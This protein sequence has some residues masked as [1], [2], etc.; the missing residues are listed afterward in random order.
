LVKFI[1]KKEKKTKIVLES[2]KYATKARKNIYAV[3]KTNE[4]ENTEQ[5]NAFRMLL[6]HMYLL[7]F[8]D[9]SKEFGKEIKEFVQCAKDFFEN[10]ETMKKNISVVIDILI[11]LLTRNNCRGIVKNFFRSVS[12]FIS[13]ESFQLLL[14]VVNPVSEQQFVGDEIMLGNNQLIEENEEMDQNDESGDDKEESSDDDD[15]MID[16]VEIPPGASVID[17]DSDLSFLKPKKNEKALEK[18]LRASKIAQEDIDGDYDIPLEN[19]N[20]EDLQRI[21]NALIT[22]FQEKNQEKTFQKNSNFFN[23][24]FIFFPPI[25]FFFYNRIE[26]RTTKYSPQT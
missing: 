14:S 1:V 25:L 13:D 9:D 26:R 5:A 17:L 11:S 12:S 19:A 2:T 24:L 18:L 7:T 21:D 16:Q 15:D 20:P 6:A 23:I 10:N 4:N 8:E 3:I 22:F